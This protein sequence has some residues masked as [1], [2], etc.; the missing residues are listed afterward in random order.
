M[1]GLLVYSE[2]V[3]TARELV[4]GGRQLGAALGLGVSAVALGP[5]AGATASELAAAGA[6]LVLSD[7]ADT[8]TCINR[9]EALL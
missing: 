2:K 7:F 1:A 8:D 3:E 5:G 9:L 4:A 6:D